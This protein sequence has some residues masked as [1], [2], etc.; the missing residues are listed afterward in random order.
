MTLVVGAFL[1]VDAA[2]GAMLTT[3]HPLSCGPS[4]GV[5]QVRVSAIA[6]IDAETSHVFIELSARASVAVEVCGSPAD[7]RCRPIGT[8]EQ[9][10]GLPLTT[11]DEAESLATAAHHRIAPR[12]C[13]GGSL[14]LASDERAPLG[15]FPLQVQS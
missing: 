14:A 1:F 12:V 5:Y 7:L 10:H 11:Q 13:A 8:G 3:C 4:N 9:W 2:Q 6:R 15:G